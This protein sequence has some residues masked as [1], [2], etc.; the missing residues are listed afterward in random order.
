MAILCTRQMDSSFIQFITSNYQNNLFL[1][2]RNCYK[3]SLNIISET[4]LSINHKYLQHKSFITHLP[5]DRLCLTR[6]NK[7]QLYI[8]KSIVCPSS[9]A[10]FYDYKGLQTQRFSFI[11]LNSLKKKKKKVLEGVTLILKHL[12]PDEVKGHDINKVLGNN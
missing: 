10:S 8:H 2:H 4:S 9:D 7:K 12:F 5:H 1:S 3:I 6:E 11:L